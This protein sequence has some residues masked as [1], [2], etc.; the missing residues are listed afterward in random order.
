MYL[1]LFFSKNCSDPNWVVDGI[2]MY[3]RTREHAN[4]KPTRVSSILEVLQFEKKVKTIFFVNRLD[5]LYD[6]DKLI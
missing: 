6:V 1:T 3:S 5:T 2:E 4:D